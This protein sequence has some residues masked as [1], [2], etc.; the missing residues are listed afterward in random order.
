MIPR[1][2]RKVMT[3]IWSQASKYRIW[4]EI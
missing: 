3:D 4:F 1:Y 2:S